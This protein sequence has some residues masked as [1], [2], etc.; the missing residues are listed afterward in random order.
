MKLTVGLYK[1]LFGK[2]KIKP[3]QWKREFLTKLWVSYLNIGKFDKVTYK[4]RKVLKR[5]I[6]QHLSKKECIAQL[7][8]K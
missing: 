7:R 2:D 1:A 6:K 4:Q 5:M 3:S 8:T